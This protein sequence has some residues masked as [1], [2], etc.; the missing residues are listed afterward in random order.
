MC[1]SG[2]L[3]RYRG[4]GGGFYRLMGLLAVEFQ[5]GI[6]SLSHASPL[7]NKLPFALECSKVQRQGRITHAGKCLPGFVE[8]H[9]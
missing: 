7:E 1:S 5:H 2:G 6:T 8:Q 4:V 3:G 9:T